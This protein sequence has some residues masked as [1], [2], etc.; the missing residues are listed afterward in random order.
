MSTIVSITGRSSGIYDDAV[1]RL[2]LKRVMVELIQ[3]VGPILS[4]SDYPVLARGLAWTIKFGVPNHHQIHYIEFFREAD[5]A[6]PVLK[7][8]GQIVELGYARV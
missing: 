2:E 7:H 4:G 3:S 8:S 6:F 1:Y 5:A